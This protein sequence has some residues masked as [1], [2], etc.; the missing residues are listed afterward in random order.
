MTMAAD[1]SNISSTSELVG[2][3]FSVVSNTYNESHDDSFISRSPVISSTPCDLGSNESDGQ[4]AE[5]R[6]KVSSSLFPE[7]G[8]H[9]STSEL[10]FKQQEEVN[11]FLLHIMN[12]TVIRDHPIFFM[13]L[14]IRTTFGLGW[15]L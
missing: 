10:L 12:E 4:P 2:Q 3:S 9:Q 13:D 8:K 6:I 1:L 7:N 14:Q 5:K 11:I 15:V